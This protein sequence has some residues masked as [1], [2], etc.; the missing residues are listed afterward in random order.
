MVPEQINEL[1]FH[2]P[3][4]DLID[5]K[6]ERS[7]AIKMDEAMIKLGEIMFAHDHVL[8]DVIELI[9]EQQ[10]DPHALDQLIT[11]YDLW[12]LAKHTRHSHLNTVDLHQLS[13]IVVKL[14][15][16]RSQVFDLYLQH[17]H[18]LKGRLYKQ[19]QVLKRRYEDYRNQLVQA[20]L[21]L[22]M[23][24]A[25]QYTGKGMELEELIQ[26]GTLGLIKGAERY[27]INKGYRF[28]TYAYWW[29][30]QAIKGALSEKRGIVRIPTNVTDR[31][32]KVERCKYEFFKANGRYPNA[33]EISSIL[34][35]DV[36]H[37]R[38]TLAVTNVGDSID[39]PIYDEGL[40]MQESMASESIATPSSQLDEEDGEAFLE[41]L[42]G[43][44]PK[45][46]QFI[47][48]LYHGIGI[49]QT[50]PFKE[51]APQI[52][53][54]LERT[55]QLYHESIRQLKLLAEHHT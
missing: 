14:E 28:T 50:Y 32:V 25:R 26:E 20:N 34:G 4:T 19:A 24:V 35:M 30:Q 38:S 47:V 23:H 5:A 37:I 8:D 45:R 52:G 17:I 40:T 27:N 54:T 36:D 49:G 6:T 51:I 10:Q 9:Q 33:K 1:T 46:Q 16:D 18:E 48:R 42:I 41:K 11:Q 2:Y 13:R 21:R 43:E 31:I 29:I 15:S 53:V 55:R 7:L 39:E 12:L 22:A 44:L 3:H